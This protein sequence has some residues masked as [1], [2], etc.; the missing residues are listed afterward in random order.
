MQTTCTS[1][2]ADN[3]TNTSLNFYRPDDLPG[4]E[5]ANTVRAL[6]ALH[7]NLEMDV[8]RFASAGRDQ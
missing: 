4:G 5:L 7:Q 6:E 2:Q 1:L 8:Y 3:Y